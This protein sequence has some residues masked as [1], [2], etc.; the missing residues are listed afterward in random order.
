MKK[1]F[2]LF[3]IFYLKSK[4]NMKDKFYRNIKIP[5]I[6]MTLYIVL[7]FGCKNKESDNTEIYKVP[8]EKEGN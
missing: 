4:F 7:F 3:T 1:D 8:N 2:F 5:V 6:L